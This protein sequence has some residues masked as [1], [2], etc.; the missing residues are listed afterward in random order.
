MAS[1]KISIPMPP[2]PRISI[3]L[4]GDWVA[5]ES[6]VWDLPRSIKEGYDVAAAKIAK[7][8]VA[9]V[10]RAIKTGLPP[11]NSGVTWQALAPTTIRVHGAHPIYN[12]TGLYSRSIGIYNYKNR[13]IVGLPLNTRLPEKSLTLN[14][15]AII[16]EHGS[17]INPD[18]TGGGIPARP[19]WRPSYKSYGG[20][21]KVRKVI[22][23]EIKKK[24][25]S[26][27][28][29]FSQIRFS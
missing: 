9:I 24:L 21:E 11:G 19:L 13:T 3:K 18:G 16:L 23:S 7:E 4:E 26:T 14:Q 27:G 15:L 28:L 20:N 12:L 8:I 5:A 10:R 29:K 22:V 17:K 25:K 6:L 2:M 1:K